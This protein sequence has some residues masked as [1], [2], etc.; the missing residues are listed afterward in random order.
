[1][2]PPSTTAPITDSMTREMSSCSSRSR[3]LRRWAVHTAGA[4]PKLS[5]L[6]RRGAVL[7]CQSLHHYIH[8]LTGRPFLEQT[9]WVQQQQG[10]VG[11]AAASG[12]TSG[13]VSEGYSGWSCAAPRVSCAAPRVNC[14]A[15][16]RV[17]SSEWTAF[18]KV[19]AMPR[20]VFLSFV[21][22][23]LAVSVRAASYSV[24]FSLG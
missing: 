24:D 5:I 17:Q 10:E 1:M 14:T 7:L 18:S 15:D 11:G 6:R 13:A 20:F 9:S 12:T 23:L 16:N 4:L 2:P 21:L 19:K 8:P 22:S 3:Q